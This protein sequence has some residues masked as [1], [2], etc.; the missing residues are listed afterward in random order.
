MQG[1]HTDNSRIKWLPPAIMGIMIFILILVL[2]RGLY[3]R[4]AANMRAIVREEANKLIT[5]IYS[6]LAYR[7]PSFERMASRWEIKQGLTEDEFT[8][9]ARHLVNDLPGIRAIEW[10]NSDFTAQWVVPLTANESEK[11]AKLAFD[12]TR[13]PAMETA[14]S[15]NIT[16]MT[17]VFALNNNENAFILYAPIYTK[18]NFDGFIGVIIEINQWLEHLLE[19]RESQFAK[20][21]FTARVSI[22]GQEVFQQNGYQPKTKKQYRVSADKRVFGKMFTVT[23]EPT[24]EFVDEMSTVLPELTFIFGSI[25][26]LLTALTIFLMTRT[27]QQ[28]RHLL[29]AKHSLESEIEQRKIIEEKLYETSSSLTLAINAGH[30]GVWSWD[31]KRDQLTWND[32]M[33]KFYGIDQDTK[34]TFDTWKNCLYPDD[35]ADTLQMLHGALKGINTFDAEFRIRT[36]TGVVRYIQAAATIEKDARGNPVRMLGVNN[37]ITERKK[38]EETIK[39]M[40]NYDLL[41]DLPTRRLATDRMKVAIKAAQRNNQHVAVM[42]MDLDGFKPVND[43]YGHKAGDAVLKEVA[44]RLLECVR[45]SDTV[46]R[47]GGDEF[48][49][50]LA[51]VNDTNGINQVA[52][53]IIDSIGQPMTYQD[54][55]FN[56]GISIGISVFPDNSNDADHLILL[57][58]KA[59]YLSKNTGKNAYTLTPPANQ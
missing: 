41:T 30:I 2:V 44:K 18:Y 50:I 51:E 33:Y 59:M 5:Y 24:S 23:V 11:D 35:A 6:D 3:Q 19:T 47:I 32:Y 4:E 38:A 15:K 8:E 26:S 25:F 36:K 13:R 22:E 40:A 55:T 20:S 52:K 7:S 49:V 46:A 16:T 48:L 57:A 10:V 17:S 1:H 28:K 39:H 45:K 56:I 31:I 54:K 43:T 29:A 58:D 9:D 12:K 37:D 34:L 14:K 21:N 53:K 27:L 42:F